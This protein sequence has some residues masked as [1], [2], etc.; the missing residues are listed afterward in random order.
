MDKIIETAPGVV[1]GATSNVLFL[2]NLTNGTLI[3]TNQMAFTNTAFM[4]GVNFL[5]AYERLVVGPDGYVWMFI[6][7]ALYRIW[8]SD[9]TVTKIMDRT[10]SCLLFNGGDLIF[11]NGTID[12]TASKTI[13][14]MK[15][16]LVQV[17]DFYIGTL[18]VGNLKTQ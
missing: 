17:P 4:S 16:M 8:P 13:Y 5:K 18:S 10:A 1:F 12:S 15:N 11:Y 6:G 14:R 9:G 3:W 7:N 2:A